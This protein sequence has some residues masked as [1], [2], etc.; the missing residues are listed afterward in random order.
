MRIKAYTLLR[1]RQTAKQHINENRSESSKT[2]KKT[3]VWPWNIKCGNCSREITVQV[4]AKNVRRI[5]YFHQR[6]SLSLS[7]KAFQTSVP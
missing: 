6:K 7:M 1:T 5:T 3:L 2:E 4:D